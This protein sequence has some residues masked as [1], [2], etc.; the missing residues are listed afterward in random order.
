M[1]TD[2]IDA[3]HP[4]ELAL[5]DLEDEIDP[6]FGELDDLRL[7][8]RSKPAVP[9]IEIED[10]LDIILHAG[11]RIDDA[12]PQLDLGRKILLVDLAVSFKS[13]AIDDRVLDDPDD[14]GIADPGQI[15]VSK[16]SGRE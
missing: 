1:V 7:D 10:A 16:K 3:A 9:A 2:E 11:A 4:G 13:D 8:R 15:D 6:V 12:R 5:V 14:E